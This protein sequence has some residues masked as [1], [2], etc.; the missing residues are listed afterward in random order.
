MDIEKIISKA[1]KAA[2]NIG[3]II[4]A[5][6]EALFK[7]TRYDSYEYERNS[8]MFDDA[9][10]SQKQDKRITKRVVTKKTSAEKKLY[11]LK[12]YVKALRKT[13]QEFG[14]FN[15]TAFK[16]RLRKYIKDNYPS[17]KTETPVFEVKLE[18]K[19]ESKDSFD[20]FFERSL[21]KLDD[22]KK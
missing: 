12:L 10:E 2:S 14:L 16:S 13:V 9:I 11:A 17:R 6:L 3:R 22:S 15:N 18:K 8:Q 5:F 4:R 19:E 20:Q 1:E 21:K 7:D